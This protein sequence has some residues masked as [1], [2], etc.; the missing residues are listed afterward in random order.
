MTTLFDYMDRYPH[1]PGSKAGGTSKKAAKLIKER[2]PTLRD[3]V[4]KLLLDVPAGLTA[5]ECAAKLN[6]SILSIRPRL[7]ELHNL[8]KIRDT[9]CTRANDS[10]V[11]AS[12]WCVNA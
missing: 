4:Y 10:G 12:V 7:S 1:A 2:A 9:G 11:Q 8:Q 5:D 3:Q 6:K